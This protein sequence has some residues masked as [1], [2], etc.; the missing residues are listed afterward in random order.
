MTTILVWAVM[1]GFFLS[2]ILNTM[3]GIWYN[4]VSV[5]S[6][7]WIALMLGTVQI[8]LGFTILVT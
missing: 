1:I 6:Y 8:I 2:G 4:S 3:M 7:R 5:D